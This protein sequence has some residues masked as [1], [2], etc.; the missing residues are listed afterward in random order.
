MLNI[1][2]FVLNSKIL[3]K[4]HDHPYFSFLRLDH[5]TVEILDEFK[6]TLYEIKTSSSILNIFVHDINQNIVKAAI[7][8]PKRKMLA[9]PEGVGKSA[10]GHEI[11]QIFEDQDR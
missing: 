9:L 11:S 7:K 4:S 3:Q 6:N 8:Y 2:E 10:I 5:N 1:E